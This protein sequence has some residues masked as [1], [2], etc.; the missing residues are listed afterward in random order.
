MN[1]LI[2]F[3]TGGIGALL[4]FVVAHD[5][6]QGVVRASAGLSL[7]V[8]LFFYAFPDLLSPE[9]TLDIPLVF[10]GASFVGMTGSHLIQSKLLILMGGVIFS[11]V[12]LASSDVFVGLGGKLGTAACISSLIVFGVGV[13]ISRFKTR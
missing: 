12:Y 3:I 1:E 7:I 13:L 10:F 6:K 2:L 9:L 8:G 4:T 5:L 11:G